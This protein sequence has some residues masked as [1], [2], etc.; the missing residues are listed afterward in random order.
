MKTSLAALALLM[1]ASGAAVA[2]EG[3]PQIPP[4]EAEPPAPPPPGPEAR[5]VLMPGH[6]HWN[7]VAYDR[8]IPT[9]WVHRHAG[10]GHFVPGAWRP[11]PAG[12]W[13]WVPEHWVS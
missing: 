10:W 13:H 2:Q 4:P 3:Y 7:G 8:W 9:H 11:D 5:W 6:W 1:M 12:G